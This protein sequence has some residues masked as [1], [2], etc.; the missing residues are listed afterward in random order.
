MYLNLLGLTLSEFFF[1]NVIYWVIDWSPN[2]Q[3]YCLS[4]GSF[5]SRAFSRANMF[6]GLGRLQSSIVH[7]NDLFGGEEKI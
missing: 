4:I 2:N 5:V 3:K 7:G 1:Q 6:E